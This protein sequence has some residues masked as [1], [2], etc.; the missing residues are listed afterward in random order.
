MVAR[1]GAQ[2]R[3]ERQGVGLVPLP[4]VGAQTCEQCGVPKSVAHSAFECPNHSQARRSVK[5]TLDRACLELGVKQ[6]HKWWT[7]SDAQKLRASFS[8]RKGVVPP[9]KGGA[10]YSRSASAWESFYEEAS[11]TPCTALDT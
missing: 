10:F 11:Q 9:Q 5:E 8:P 6:N 3:L 7:L 4:E 1:R 2:F